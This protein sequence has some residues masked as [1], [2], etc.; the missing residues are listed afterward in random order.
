MGPGESD[1]RSSNIN[2]YN[3]FRNHSLWSERKQSW[4]R[5][6]ENAGKHGKLTVKGLVSRMKNELPKSA[7]W[8]KTLGQREYSRQGACLVCD[9]L[10]FNLNITNGLPN[11]ARTVSLMQSQDYTLRKSVCL[12]NKN[13]KHLGILEV[14]TGFIIQGE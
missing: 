8:C 10:R 11:P 9:Q 7:L 2:I 3:H 4:S 14:T 12:Q 6:L 5:Q 13:R 1:A